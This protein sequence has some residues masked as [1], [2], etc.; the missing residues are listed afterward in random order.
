LYGNGKNGARGKK[1]MQELDFIDKD[2]LL[3][4]EID[5]TGID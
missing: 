4:K 1:S 2:E 3:R 5:E